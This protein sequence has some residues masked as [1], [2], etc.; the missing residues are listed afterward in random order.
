MNS[1][2]YAV[3][4]AMQHQQLEMVRAAIEHSLEEARRRSMQTSETPNRKQRRAEK[5]RRRKQI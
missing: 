5:A 4:A 3:N 1:W 2:A